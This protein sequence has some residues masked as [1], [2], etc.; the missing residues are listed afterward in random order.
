[1][2]AKR[3]FYGAALVSV[4]GGGPGQPTLQPTPPAPQPAANSIETMS[5]RVRF[6]FSSSF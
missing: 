5:R 4:R 6:T 3:T 2:I 1:M